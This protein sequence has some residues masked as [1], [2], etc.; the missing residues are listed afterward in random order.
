MQEFSMHQLVKFMGIHL[1]I[2]K[3]KH[4]LEIQTASPRSCYDEGKRISETLIYEYINKL[5]V[6]ARIGR[7][8][9][10]YGLHG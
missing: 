6:D 2:H 1:S 9:N 5:K 10:T 4:I 7:I 8:F 3:K